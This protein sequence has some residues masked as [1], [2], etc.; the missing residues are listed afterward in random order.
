MLL[1]AD[2][3]GAYRDS[4]GGREHERRARGDLAQRVAAGGYDA[5]TIDVRSTG[6]DLEVQALFHEEPEPL[7]DHFSELVSSREPAELQV[8]DGQ[9]VDVATRG[10][11]AAERKSASGDDGPT[12]KLP[13]S[14]SA[15]RVT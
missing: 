14:Q 8:E 1:D 3:E 12:E 5:D 4:L 6:V 10:D 11:T 2:A 7:C 9:A 13:P 15:A